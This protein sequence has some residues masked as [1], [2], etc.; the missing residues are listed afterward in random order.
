MREY[1]GFHVCN[2]K[3]TVVVDGKE[4]QGKWVFGWAARCDN[5]CYIYISVSVLVEA[6]TNSHENYLEAV[7]V[8]PSTVGQAIGRKDENGVN[9]FEGDCDSSDDEL[10]VVAWDEESCAFGLV[11]PN[12][13][14]YIDCC[15]SWEYL[16][17][18]GTIFDKKERN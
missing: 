6:E 4:Y 14:D 15:V 9:I 17:I 2:G 11:Y 8:L 18:I 12:G 7:E 1:R 3:E 16:K 13:D 5:S 10:M